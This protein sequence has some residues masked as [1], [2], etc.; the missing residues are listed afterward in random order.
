MICYY[1][2]EIAKVA[3]SQRLHEQR[4][5]KPTTR[6][7]SRCG[8]TLR[9]RLISGQFEIPSLPFEVRDLDQEYVIFDAAT[10][11]GI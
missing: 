9:C 8:V 10:V 5:G 1:A 6:L 11:E 4:N 3:D 7:G 2:N